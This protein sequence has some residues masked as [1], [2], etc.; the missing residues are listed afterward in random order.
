MAPEIGKGWSDAVLALADI[1]N[2]CE[3]ELYKM[4]ESRVGGWRGVKD[5]KISRKRLASDKCMEITFE[6][7]ENAGPIEF[8]PGQFL[9]L[10][11]REEGATPR[12]Y[13][14]TSKKGDPFLQCCVNI[15][16]MV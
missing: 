1:L 14:V 15:L 7:V 5:F 3:E 16:R 8:T 2:K 9:T 12:H 6:S 10:H 11:L 13:T 4:A